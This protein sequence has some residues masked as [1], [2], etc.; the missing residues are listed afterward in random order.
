MSI[1][2][3][4]IS[5]ARDIEIDLIGFCDI[6]FDEGLINFLKEKRELGLLTGFEEENEN[7]RTDIKKIM[8]D[9]QTIIAIA[10]PYKTADINT[11]QIHISKSSIGLDY[12]IVL[13]EKLLKLC[14]FLIEKY[15]AKAVSFCDN[16]P[17]CEREIARKSGIG[18]IGKNNSLITKKYGSYVFL[19][20]IITN[21]YIER[22]K[23]VENKCGSCTICLNACPSGALLK[24]WYIDPRK[25]ISFLTQKKEELTDS[26]KKLLGL[27]IYG[28]D[29]CQDVCPY[30]KTAEYSKIEEFKP[31]GWEANINPDFI[32]GLTNSEYKRTFKKVSCGWR[33][34][35]VLKR[36]TLIAL[37]NLKRNK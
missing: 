11:K 35:R 10:L 18:F 1:K 17:L 30:N 26:E 32:L 13:K 28:C 25:C 29:T 23:A 19:G 14:N 22:D 36:N 16:N 7:K 5:F 9:A 3:E 31:F 33:G 27:N 12:H 24:P 2:E 21:I 8:E 34:K 6:N 15:G 4:I 20:E 37:E